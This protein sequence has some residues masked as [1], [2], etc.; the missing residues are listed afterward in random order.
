MS[1][2]KDHISKDDPYLPTLD[3][4][5]KITLLSSKALTAL[6]GGNVEQA[7]GML[8]AIGH[9][10]RYLKDDFLLWLQKDDETE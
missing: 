9:L 10:S 1:Q 4:I 2:Q 8:Q 7:K 5:E 3:K 6:E